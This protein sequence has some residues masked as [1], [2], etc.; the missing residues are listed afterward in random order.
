MRRSLLV[1]TLA[2]LVMLSGC[3]ALDGGDAAEP[4]PNG[5]AVVEPE[6]PATDAADTTQSIR[7]T[8]NESVAGS[9]WSS[10]SAEYP[11]DSFTVD[12]VQH[13]DVGLGVDTNNDSEVD[14]ELNETHI[15]GVNNNDYSFTVELDSGYTLE[16]GDVIVVE[17]PGITNPSEAGEYTVAVTINDAQ[18]ENATVTIGDDAGD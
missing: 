8:A 5:S 3:A 6:D 11:R 15:S 1:V 14:R 17:Y 9:E 12:S 18:T 4:A 16:D 7:V 10:L 13:R 2:V